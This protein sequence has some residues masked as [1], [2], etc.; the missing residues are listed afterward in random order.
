MKT[1]DDDDNTIKAFPLA[2][3]VGRVRSKYRTQAAFSRAC[4]LVSIA[5]GVRRV[6]HELG[7]FGAS[8]VIISTNVKPTLS[9]FPSRET[10]HY[11]G[12]PGVADPGVAVYFRLKNLPHAMCC[13]KW[14]RVADN[15]AAI[16]KHVEATRG[17]L[18][19]GCADAAQAFAGFRE[20]P[21]AEAKRPWWQ[22]MGF[23]TR[24]ASLEVVSRKRDELA[25]RHHPDMGGNP[26][27]MA[28]INAAYDEG[29]LELGG[30]R[31]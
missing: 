20:L 24:P 1:N 17:Q 18:R 5:E 3:P 21:A 22:I 10:P 25:R 19:W 15:L 9:G 13:D 30:G 27:Q 12:N 8:S 2:W 16:A 29:R 7:L 31:A 23:P 14:L 28:E 11:G 26:N 6:L 4:Q